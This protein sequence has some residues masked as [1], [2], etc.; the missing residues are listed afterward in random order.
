MNLSAVVG[1]INSAEKY[2]MFIQNF[3]VG[4]RGAQAGEGPTASR[5]H[6][7]ESLKRPRTF[8][9]GQPLVAHCSKKCNGQCRSCT[10]LV[11]RLSQHAMQTLSNGKHISACQENGHMPASRSMPA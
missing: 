11:M 7:K 5:G 9:F 3:T 2:E 6:A 4:V 8:V 1:S 10:Y